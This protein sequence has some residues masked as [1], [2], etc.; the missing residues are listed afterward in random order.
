MFEFVIFTEAGE[1]SV[2]VAHLEGSLLTA[3]LIGAVLA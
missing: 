2:I 3:G 1:F